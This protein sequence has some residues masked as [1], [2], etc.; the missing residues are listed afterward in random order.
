MEISDNDPTLAQ[1][2]ERLSAGESRMEAKTAPEVTDDSATAPPTAPADAETTETQPPETKPDDTL[3]TTD[4]KAEEQPKPEGTEPKGIVDPKRDPKSGKFAKDFDRRVGSW[5]ELNSR[6][7]EHA[8]LEADLK[9]Q[10]DEFQRQKVAFEKQQADARKA[11]TKTP[12]HYEQEAANLERAAEAAEKRSDF[13]SADEMRAI[14]RASKRFAADLR[15]NPPP[16]DPTVEQADKAF[17]DEQEKW[18]KKAAI[19][20][21]ALQNKDGK[22][23]P[24][25]EL[26]KAMTTPGSDKF[27]Q[28]VAEAVKTSPAGLYYAGRLANA[29]TV[30]ARV[31]T[32][33]KD[34]ADARA[35]VKKLNGKLSVNGNGLATV[36]PSKPDAR[37][38]P[39]GNLGDELRAQASQVRLSDLR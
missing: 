32:L 33:E 30:A 38:V 8:K 4:P 31:P 18:G 20:F 25:M 16:P 36:Q 37:N 26:L 2:M 23:S 6:K 7:E 21:P 29:E 22:L 28:I 15:A 9:R 13:D 34:L 35:E 39:L 14:A 3:A 17:G 27:D 11:T 10:V 19:D 5:K 12:E 1:A 24:A